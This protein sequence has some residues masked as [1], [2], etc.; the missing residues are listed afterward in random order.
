MV[1]GIH[2]LSKFAPKKIEPVK[3]YNSTH[4]ATVQNSHSPK[5]HVNSRHL[6]KPDIAMAQVAYRFRR[7]GVA[8]LIVLF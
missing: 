2:M 5:K 7:G 6:D 4:V 8:S 3:C 1:A